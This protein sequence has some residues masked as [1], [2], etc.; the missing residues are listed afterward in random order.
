MSSTGL[1][2]LP[3]PI[4]VLTRRARNAKSPKERHDTAYY[5]WEASVRLLV[6]WRPP[7]DVSRLARPSTGQWVR[8]AQLAS[9]KYEQPALLAVY[10]LFTEIGAQRRAQPRTVEPRKLIDALP[11]YRNQVL[12]HG[13]IRP[14]DF[15]ASA[16][17]VLLDG[18]IAAWAGGL[19]LP[20][21]ADLV[22]VDSV[23]LAPDGSRAARVLALSGLG[24]T[25]VGSQVDV[26][27]HVHPGRVHVRNL[28]EWTS[29]HPWILFEADDLRER[30]WFFNA[31]K[32]SAQYLDFASGETLMGDAVDALV[33]A[34]Q[35]RIRE[36]FSTQALQPVPAE[37]SSDKRFGDYEVIGRLGEGGM[38]V[39]YLA[40]QTSIDR[41]VALKMLPSSIAADPLAI[42]RF[43][44]EI[45]ALSRCDHPNVV[46]IFA[47]GEAKGTHY[48]AMEYLEGADLAR[49]A[50][51][52]STQDDVSLAISQAAAEAR[53]S[54]GDVF[55]DL[56]D[57]P[58]Q[59][60]DTQ[61]PAGGL[62]R[63]RHL[64]TLMRD[65][66]MGLGH[67]HEAGILHRDIKP[68]NL[69]VSAID[70]R[71]VVMDLGLAAIGDASRNL[72]RDTSA[73]LGTLRYM[74]PEQLQRSQMR[75]DQRADLFSLGATFYEL[76]TGVPLRDGETEPD[77]LEQ[78]LRG[79]AG[80]AAAVNPEV[81]ADLWAILRKVTE[82]DPALRY[83]T[84]AALASDLDS[85]LLGRPIAARSP[86]VRYVLRLA[87]RRNP[88]A[89]ATG[90]LALGSL[91]AFAITM[92]VLWRQSEANLARALEAESEAALQAETA[93]AATDFMVRLFREAHPGNA[94]GTDPTARDVLDRGAERIAVELKQDERV[95]L[96]MLLAI[97]GAYGGLGA[98]EQ[99]TPLLEEAN[100]LANR[101]LAKD[102]P[103]RIRVRRQ[104]A[105]ILA[106]NMELDEARAIYEELLTIVEPPSQP[107]MLSSI[108]E[109]LKKQGRLEEAEE[110]GARA[111]E[112]ARKHLP[113]EHPER[114]NLFG[115]RGL[116]LMSANRP[117]EALALLEEV[118]GWA[119]ELPPNDVERLDVAHSLALVRM[120]T[121]D[122]SGMALME[123]VV[124]HKIRVYGPSHRSTLRSQIGYAEALA[125]TGNLERASEHA[126]AAMRAADADYEP[127]Q[128][129]WLTT[130]LRAALVLHLGGDNA[131]A[132]T[133]LLRIVDHSGDAASGTIHMKRQAIELLAKMMLDQGRYAEGLAYVETA[134]AELAKLYGENSIRRLM[135][136]PAYIAALQG[137]GRHSEVIE[138]SKWLLTTQRE[139]LPPQYGDQ[140]VISMMN[141][142]GSYLAM[143]DLEQAEEMLEGAY[144]GAQSLPAEHGLWDNLLSQLASV[145]AKRGRADQAEPLFKT[146][147]ERI[148][149][150]MD[151]AS[152]AYRDR[153]LL[154]AH[155]AY[156]LPLREVA[157]LAYRKHIEAIEKH[158]EPTADA[159]LT[160]LERQARQLM[161]AA[162]VEEAAKAIDPIADV[163]AARPAG[164]PL[165]IQVQQTLASVRA[166]QGRPQEAVSLQR[167]VHAA[168][169]DDVLAL[170]SLASYLQSAGEND[171]AEG[172]LR[173]AIATA[174]ESLAPGHPAIHQSQVVQARIF[175]ATGRPGEAL[176]TLR[177]AV[178]GGLAKPDAL[179][180]PAF[181]SLRQELAFGAVTRDVEAA[182]RREKTAGNA[183][184]PPVR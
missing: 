31:L 48:Y 104:Y 167:Q 138:A 64:A 87:A 17:T 109:I 152:R 43:R 76:V 5:A 117:D 78:V 54:R 110:Y 165:R 124:E 77:L 176:A 163:A 146:Y 24:A 18:L 175:A 125:R 154:M 39:V 118:Y 168:R 81:P 90:V 16:A 51:H 139:V 10:G 29:L 37:E 15:Y 32:R 34:T 143:G 66:A 158:L 22:F 28:G 134:D 126:T 120:M 91:V 79:P 172:H 61:L 9:N 183:T 88:V 179:S 70:G 3:L 53:E 92:G 107:V 136:Y 130:A 94:R 55:A 145:R 169:P 182:K 20:A 30:T 174:S 184:P 47:S 147:L 155:S 67:L 93:D 99:A 4:A 8:A 23:E 103:T 156:W 116:D 57:I 27:A 86:T 36:V 33:P 46:K 98:S 41:R 42:A 73:L 82:P 11:A 148:D 7:T 150:E 100:E 74:A 97:G 52:L 135:G 35:T 161:I 113:P 114:L 80:A 153:L 60:T 127:T 181:D 49:I 129:N 25:L 123:E 160:S 63:Y 170:I 62:T 95:R 159:A 40:Q 44:R 137:V 166:A 142:A 112:M 68:S 14:N 101:L 106:M 13:S 133:L 71:P 56:P 105:S 180:D 131:A 1:A 108:F 83:D 84:A 12:G 19:L 177:T 173:A 122:E 102:D 65:V 89:A 75:V 144:A 132:E 111:R 85:W 164:D 119:S 96:P 151:P 45:D 26:P 171:E 72:T 58:R 38:G 69:L 162:E 50:R 140:L 115:N 157:A 121:G 6:G 178:D 21:G 149:K 2:S 59:P 128:Y 141:M